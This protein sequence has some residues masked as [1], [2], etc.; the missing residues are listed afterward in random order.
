MT[1]NSLLN[2]APVVGNKRYLSYST[3]YWGW[4]NR[5]PLNNVNIFCNAFQ[6]NSFQYFWG[7]F[8]LV[9]AFQGISFQYFW[10]NFDL[11]IRGK[12]LGLDISLWGFPR[13]QLAPQAIFLDPVQKNWMIHLKILGFGHLFM[14]ISKAKN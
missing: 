1:K 5:R 6:G 7:N 10:C 13:Q 12:M 8:D 3:H 14:G 11:G 4:E 9:Y 2:L